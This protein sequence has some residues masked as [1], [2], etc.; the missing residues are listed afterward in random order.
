MTTLDTTWVFRALR[1]GSPPLQPLLLAVRR[2][3]QQLS[4][5]PGETQAAV[6]HTVPCEPHL[7]FALV[8]PVSFAV[9]TWA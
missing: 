2:D 9:P 5:A 6:P 4:A 7:P 1:P 8:P 3:G